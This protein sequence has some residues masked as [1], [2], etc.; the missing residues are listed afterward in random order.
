MVVNQ[1]ASPHGAGWSQTG[2]WLH[3]TRARRSRHLPRR[4]RRGRRGGRSHPGVL[5]EA[6]ALQSHQMDSRNGFMMLYELA[7]SG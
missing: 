4:H 5:F 1:C 7:W 6:R 2:R 3:I